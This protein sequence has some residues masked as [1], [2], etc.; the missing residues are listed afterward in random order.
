M[1]VP[2][3]LSLVR[4]LAILPDAVH[5][6]A[7]V[8]CARTLVNTLTTPLRSYRT[9]THL[10]VEADTTPHRPS[11]PAAANSRRTNCRPLK[12]HR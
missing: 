10:A 7:T 8:K 12:S 6:H 11:P 5:T 3:H 1:T 4:P 9:A 2:E